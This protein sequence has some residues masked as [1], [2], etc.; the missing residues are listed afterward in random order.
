[1]SKRLIIAILAFLPFVYSCKHSN[2]T[3][4]NDTPST[5]T[6]AFI[7]QEEYGIYSLKDDLSREALLFDMEANQFISSGKTSKLFYKVLDFK[8]STYLH[9]DFASG[10]TSLKEGSTVLA[11]IVIDGV[12][13]ISGKYENSGLEIV[14]VTSG[15]TYLRDNIN[16]IG[17]IIA[18]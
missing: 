14:K 9:L 15:K 7:E 10:V 4:G 11:D 1:M 12:D 17:Y 3:S 2:K 13:G 6:T 18:Q 8:K 5:Y 16:N